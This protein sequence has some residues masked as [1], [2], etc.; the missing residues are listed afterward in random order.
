MKYLKSF[1][2]LNEE[3]RFLNLKEVLKYIED[4]SSV[5]RIEGF[6][7][8]FGIIFTKSIFICSDYKKQYKYFII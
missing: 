6:E 3:N 1:S 4:L 5:F 8:L 7:T 2:S